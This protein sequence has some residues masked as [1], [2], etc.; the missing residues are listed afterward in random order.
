MIDQ[1]QIED[2]VKAAF[3]KLLGNKT[4]LQGKGLITRLSKET[5]LDKLAVQGALASLAQSQWMSGVYANG[6]PTGTVTPL[7]ERPSIPTPPSLTSWSSAMREV[8]LDEKEMSA[9]LPAHT[10]VYDFSYNDMVLLLRGLIQLRTD[11]HT[12][13]RAPSFIISAKY[14]L[15]SSKILDSLPNK[16]IRMFGIDTSLFTGAP[17]VVLIAG[18]SSPINVVLIENPHAFW[19]ALESTAIEK[20]AFLVTFGYG[21]SRHGDDFGSQLVSL[22]ENKTS[23]IGAICAG[24]P[25]S[26]QEMLRHKNISFWGDLDVE[27]IRIFHRLKKVIPQLSLSSLY[28]PMLKA[29][30]DPTK[31]HA[32]VQSAAKHKQVG[33]R[34]SD[35]GREMNCLELLNACRERAV[36]QETVSCDEIALYADGVYSAPL[37]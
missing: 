30:C 19:R 15:G 11:Q 24:S 9:L 2:L 1:Q 37:S 10:T 31:S 32:Y 7:T 34:P 35:L 21:L 18:P 13:G 12:L 6:I 23:L 25:P 4:S 5:L 16:V 17:P 8:G 3:W 26:V 27:G 28:G 29:V 20:T 14:L 36:D 33:V 22:L